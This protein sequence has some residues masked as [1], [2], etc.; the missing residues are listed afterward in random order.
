MSRVKARKK[1]SRRKK[2]QREEWP[3]T[4]YIG[5]AAGLLLGYTIGRIALNGY[6]HPYHWLSGLVGGVIGFLLGWVWYWRRGDV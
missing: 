2:D 6:P 1:P 5:L 4:V 3:L